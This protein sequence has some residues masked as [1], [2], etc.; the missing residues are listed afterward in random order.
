[1]NAASLAALG[2]AFA[3]HEPQLRALLHRH[4]GTAAP[5]QPCD[6]LQD[7]FLKA[8]QRWHDFQPPA[9]N[10]DAA[11]FRWLVHVTLS[12]LRDQWDRVRAARRDHRRQEPWPA[13][14][15]LVQRMI[16]AQPRTGPSTAAARHELEERVRE[17]LD[18]L[19][20]DARQVLYLT[21][22]EG[23]PY[24]EVAAIL[25]IKEGAARVR[26]LRAFRRLAELWK[27]VYPEDA[28]ML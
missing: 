19:E 26:H 9:D 14:S 13:S 2:Q 10:P 23:R 17:L 6:V 18:C 22:I 20:P 24:A 4:L 11:T 5:F 3:R 21:D 27:E 15:L 1:M 7:A 25:G 28:Q 8:S 12:C 16:Q